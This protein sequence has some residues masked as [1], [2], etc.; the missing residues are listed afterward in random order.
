MVH[1]SNGGLSGGGAGAMIF[2]AA[3]TL[4]KSLL[5]HASGL[6]AKKIAKKAALGAVTAGAGYGTTK[7][8]NVWIERID[9]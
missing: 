8:L 4:A 2:K 5:K 9:K 6:M 3:A 1:G 7:A